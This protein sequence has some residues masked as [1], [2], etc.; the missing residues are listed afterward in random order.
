MTEE[1]VVPLFADGGRTVPEVDEPSDTFAA[2]GEDDI[3]RLRGGNASDSHRVLIDVLADYDI[4]VCLTPP[5]GSAPADTNVGA[6]MRP[7]KTTPHTL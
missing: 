7:N 4:P 6:L 3:A 1:N 2:L 5:T